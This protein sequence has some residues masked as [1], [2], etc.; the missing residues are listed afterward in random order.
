MPMTSKRALE[1]KK[2]CPLDP[3]WIWA[4]TNFD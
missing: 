3:V 2:I 4:V 1:L